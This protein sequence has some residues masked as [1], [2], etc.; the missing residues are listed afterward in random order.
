MQKVFLLET[1]SVFKLI[2]NSRS[3]KTQQFIN[4]TT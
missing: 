3:A 2:P 4:F 1:E